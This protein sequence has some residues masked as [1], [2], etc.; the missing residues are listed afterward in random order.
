[1]VGEPGGPAVMNFARLT[2]TFLITPKSELF[3]DQAVD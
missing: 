3:E 2:G 1:M